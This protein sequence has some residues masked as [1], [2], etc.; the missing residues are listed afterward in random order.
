MI[1]LVVLIIGL[2]LTITA[3]G[4]ESFEEMDNAEF[5]QEDCNC[6]QEALDIVREYTDVTI[7]VDLFR[8]RSSVECPYDQ[9]ISNSTHERE[10]VCMMQWV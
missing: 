3:F 4:R 6:E 10:E 7:V 8:N 2:Q 9:L 5:L 1:S